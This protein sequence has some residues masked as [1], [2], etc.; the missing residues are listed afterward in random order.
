VTVDDG[1]HYLLTTTRTYDV[2]TSEPPPPNHAGVVNLYSREYYRA[3]RHAL[4]PGGV[5]AQW[6]PVVQLSED[7]MLAMIGAV[8]AEFPY[9]ELRYGFNYQ[10]ILLGSDTR[11]SWSE[12]AWNRIASEAAVARDLAALGVRGEPDL[13]ATLIQ[14]D[15][16]LR[17]ASRMVAPV[18]DDLP[19]IEYPID[20]VPRPP[21]I[22]AA[23]VGD[24]RDAFTGKVPT[25][26]DVD[27]ALTMGIVLRALPL[28]SAGS[29]EFRELALGTTLRAA[30]RLAPR[31]PA[32]FALLDVDDIA[33][34]AAEAWLALHPTDDAASFLLAR[35]AFYENDFAGADARLAAM[36]PASVSAATYWFLRG[37]CADALGRPDDAASAFRRAVAASS[38]ERFRVGLESLPMRAPV[39]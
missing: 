7:D 28:R 37:S 5:L 27:A 22:P 12:D 36:D 4:R 17:A 38:D 13:A 16:A 23:L 6:L 19:S 39:P 30:L 3:A 26:A 8:A 15:A 9:L 24:P 18:D 14:G 32:I 11:P 1:R 29:P 35:R 2:I 33:C 31:H 21:R 34:D 25:P 20:S 10:W